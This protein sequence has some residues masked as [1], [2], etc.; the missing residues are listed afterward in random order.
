MANFEES[1]EPRR[2]PVKR[3]ARGLRGLVSRLMQEFPPH[4]EFR[5]RFGRNLYEI[6]Q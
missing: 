3:L 5:R 4:E 2:T 6:E 1:D